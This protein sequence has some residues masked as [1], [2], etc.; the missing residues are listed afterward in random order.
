MV[1]TTPRMEWKCAL[2]DLEKVILLVYIEVNSEDLVEK[3]KIYGDR[4]YLATVAETS[5][6]LSKSR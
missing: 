4:G 3:A 5:T 1:T 6:E 2:R